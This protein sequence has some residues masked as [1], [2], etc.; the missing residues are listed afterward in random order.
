MRSVP[1]RTVRYR[2][3]EFGTVPV[4]TS[5]RTV[6]YRGDVYMVPSYQPN[7]SENNIKAARVKL[8]AIEAGVKKI[9][10]FLI[11][12]SKARENP[13]LLVVAAFDIIQN[14]ICS[15]KSGRDPVTLIDVMND[16]LGYTAGVTQEARE[17]VSNLRQG[18]LDFSGSTLDQVSLK[19]S[20]KRI[21]EESTDLPQ[22]KKLKSQFAGM[23]HS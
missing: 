10:S 17:K 8:G 13:L 1:Y 6:P 19:K 18:I 14:S 11:D 3:V 2:K 9:Y 12:L 23:L 16:P 22:S 20:T 15:F 4:W 7:L 5:Y 21:S